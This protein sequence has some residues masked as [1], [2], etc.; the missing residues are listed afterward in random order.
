MASLVRIRAYLSTE[1]DRPSFLGRSR[2]DKVGCRGASSSPT[3]VLGRSRS[4]GT[5]LFGGWR[6]TYERRADKRRTKAVHWLTGDLVVVGF[7][8][9]LF[10]LG[11]RGRDTGGLAFTARFGGVLDNFLFDLKRR[12]RLRLS[13]LGPIRYGTCLRENRVDQYE[14]WG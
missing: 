7:D 1:I 6:E 8:S 12:R 3:D 13:T 14:G 9:D 4:R 5:S 10:C 11:G 2:R